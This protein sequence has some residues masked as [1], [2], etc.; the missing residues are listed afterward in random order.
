MRLEKR[1]FSSG[2]TVFSEMVV[3]DRKNDFATIPNKKAFKEKQVF[4]DMVDVYWNED[5]WKAYNI[6]EP[7]E[8]LEH[9]VSKLKNNPVRFQIVFLIFGDQQ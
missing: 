3:T 8:S 2:Y 6:I 7:T 9:A 1:L 4:Y 5:F